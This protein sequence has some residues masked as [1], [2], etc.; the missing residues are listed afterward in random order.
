MTAA[1][2]AVATDA[3]LDEALRR[4]RQVRAALAE[5]ASW[6]MIGA[7]VGMSGPQAKRSYHLLERDTRRQ[8]LLAALADV[9]SDLV[10]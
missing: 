10:E 8:F 6:A 2:A 1:P 3:E 4:V 9:P 5:G 7:K